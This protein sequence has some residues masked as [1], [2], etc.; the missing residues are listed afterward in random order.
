MSRL[1]IDHGV[2]LGLL[3]SIT[4]VPAGM[5]PAAPVP[6]VAEAVPVGWS[7]KSPRGLTTKS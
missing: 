2:Q 7:R 1:T 4:L 6:A 3:S 5:T